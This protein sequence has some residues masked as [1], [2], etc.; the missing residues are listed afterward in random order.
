MKSATWYYHA[1]YIEFTY[2]TSFTGYEEYIFEVVSNL[3]F[4]DPIL[5]EN[6]TDLAKPLLKNWT[7]SFRASELLKRMD[8]QTH[9]RAKPSWICAKFY[10]LITKLA[11]QKLFQIFWLNLTKFFSN[12]ICFWVISVHNLAQ[13]FMNVNSDRAKKNH[14]WKV[15][16]R[17]SWSS[18]FPSLWFRRASVLKILTHLMTE[19]INAMNE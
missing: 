19:L 8:K 3:L 18:F 15:C 9:V 1:I 5:A 17:S 11:K 6:F 2:F 4:K 13:N 10:L 12:I 16:L 14:F 7:Q